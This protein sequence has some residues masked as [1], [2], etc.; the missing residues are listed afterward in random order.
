MVFCRVT[1]QC[2][3]DGASLCHLTCMMQTTLQKVKAKQSCLSP[4]LDIKAGNVGSVA[5]CEVSVGCLLQSVGKV[6]GVCCR[7]WGKCGVSVAECGNTPGL[8]VSSCQFQQNTPK[9]QM[10]CLLQGARTALPLVM[11]CGI[12]T[13]CIAVYNCSFCLACSYVV[14]LALSAAESENY[15]TPTQFQQSLSQSAA[16]SSCYA[17]GQQASS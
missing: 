14:T 15:L 7:V 5:E 13:T 16:L 6:W 2:C 1:P 11:L 8:P 9:W 17:L 3:L 12:F 4:C 10:W